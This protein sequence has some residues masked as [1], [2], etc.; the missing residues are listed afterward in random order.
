MRLPILIFVASLLIFA[1]FG[2]HAVARKKFFTSK[3]Q[4][5]TKRSLKDSQNAIGICFSSSEKKSGALEDKRVVPTGPN[6]L[7]NK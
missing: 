3:F 7:H 5:A 1:T 4:D 2:S 6:P